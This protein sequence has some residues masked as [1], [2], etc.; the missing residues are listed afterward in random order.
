[1][2]AIAITNRISRRSSIRTSQ[3]EAFRSW[4]NPF[5][6]VTSMIRAE[7]LMVNSESQFVQVIRQGIFRSGI[8]TTAPQAGQVAGI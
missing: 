3:G 8:R 5:N 1:M 6:L 7:R 4:A 2:T